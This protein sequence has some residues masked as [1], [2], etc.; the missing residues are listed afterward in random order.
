VNH[1]G[2]CIDVMGRLPDCSVDMVL[3]DVPYGQ[4]QNVWDKPIPFIPMWEQLF[5]VSKPNAAIV[6]MAAQP[7]TTKLGSS[8]LENLRYT[9]VWRKNR[10]TG[11]LNAKRRP[12]VGH[13]DICVFYREQPTF[14]IQLKD[15]GYKLRNGFPR[16]RTSNY[17][18]VDESS[19]RR[20]DNGGLVTSDSVLD[21]DCEI[22]FH[23][24]QKP[25]ALMAWLIRAYTNSGDTVLDFAAGS[26]TTAVAALREGRSYICI[27]QKPEYFEISESR[28]AAERGVGTQLEAAP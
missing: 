7:F 17:G 27:E 10:K 18:S 22:G 2:D 28:I 15:P 11:N 1:C 19:Y 13:E 3:S 21:F 14:N 4:T 16:S 8:N 6:L 9:Y 25:V 26:G 23:P 24:T 12:M 20:P 5:R